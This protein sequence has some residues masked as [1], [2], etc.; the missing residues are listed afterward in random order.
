VDRLRFRTIFVSDVHLGTSDCRADQL[1]DF[2]RST[3]A[4]RLYLV[5]DIVDLE[6]LGRAPYWPAS[7]STVVAELLDLAM[8]GTAV[9][10]IPGNHDAALRDLAGQRIGAIEV[11]GSRRCTAAPTDDASA[12]VM[13]TSSTPN[14]R[15][16]PG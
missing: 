5:G 6:A 15:A 16:K 3:R 11:K 9:I 13:V 7:H 12:P 2:L 14:I 8:R 1:L 10:Y 4:E